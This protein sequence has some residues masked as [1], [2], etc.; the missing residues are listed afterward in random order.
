MQT[1]LFNLL[2]QAEHKFNV[3]FGRHQSKACDV[4]RGMNKLRGTLNLH[5]AAAL[6]SISCPQKT[7]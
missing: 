1:F 7:R 4:L 3:R 6:S 2:G 5:I